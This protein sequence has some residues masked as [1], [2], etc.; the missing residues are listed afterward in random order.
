MLKF[1]SVVSWEFWRHFKSRNFLI[2]TFVTPLFF[3]AILLLPPF[4]YQQSNLSHLKSV[5]II[6]FDSKKYFQMLLDRL[7]D[8]LMVYDLS[9][10]VKLTKIVADT[11]LKLSN[12]FARQRQLK[13]ELDSLDTAYNQIKERRKYIFLR[14]ESN[15]RESLLKETYQQLHSAREGRDLAVIEHARVK[16]ITDSSIRSLVMAKADSFLNSKKIQAYIVVEPALFKNGIVEF[17]SR[18]PI[19]FLRVDR[20]KQALQMVLLQERMRDEGVTTTK[21]YDWLRPVEIRELRLAGA[22]KRQFSVFTTYLG[23]IIVMLFLFISIFTSS[24]FL[25]RDVIQEKSNR[26]VEMV[27]TTVNSG[28]FLMG[29]IIGLGLLGLFQILIWVVLVLLIIYLDFVPVEKIGFLNIVNA[30]IFV[31]YYILGFL[32]FSSIFIGIGSMFSSE[33]EAHHIKQLM[34]VLSVF[35]IVL[36]IIV[37]DSPN[38]TFVKIMSFIPF[39]TP[40]FMVLRTPIGQPPYI[41]YVI[42]IAILFIASLIIL[43]F[44]MRMYKLGNLVFDKKVSPK[45]IFSI[46]SR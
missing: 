17:H 26:V 15:T 12:Y 16:S 7:N 13:K 31:I 40:T 39:L 41:D 46:F 44:A 22:E 29:K 45:E 42:S 34:W 8:S 28:V 20:L 25:L 3:A 23:P 35:P 32:F 2:A 14:P 27:L 33:V 19:N 4:F 24:G 43:I 9:V 37:L 30:G 38:S 18:F 6:E 21:I 5:G 1:F 11:S 10:P 36:A